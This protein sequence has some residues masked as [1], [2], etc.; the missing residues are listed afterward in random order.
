[1]K[2]LI[3]QLWISVSIPL[4]IPIIFMIWLALH[5]LANTTTWDRVMEMHFSISS[6]L[7]TQHTS[8]TDNSS[9][10]SFRITAVFFHFF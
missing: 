2:C 8:V 1:M 10:I 6:A 5:A 9:S 7:L 3:F 4:S